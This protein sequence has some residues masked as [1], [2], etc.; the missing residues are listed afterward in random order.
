MVSL[1]IGRKKINLLA[2]KE[3]ALTEKAYGLGRNSMKIILY[4]I[5][6]L[7]IQNLLVRGHV[8]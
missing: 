4:C 1:I 8:E 7:I 6:Y 5:R 3:V 2:M